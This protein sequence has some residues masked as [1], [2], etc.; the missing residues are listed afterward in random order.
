MNS[1]EEFK[2]FCT[3]GQH[4]LCKTLDIDMS[5][6]GDIMF[7]I[8]IMNK[9]Y[10]I[11]KWLVAFPNNNIRIKTPNNIAYV[12]SCIDGYLDVTKMLLDLDID[13]KYINMGFTECCATGNLEMCKELIIL[14]PYDNYNE[15]FE[16]S[17][18][19]NHMHMCQWILTLCPDATI[20][21]YIFNQC[22][23]NGH[24]EMCCWLLPNINN[25]V[26]IENKSPL[27]IGMFKYSPLMDIFVKCCQ[28]GHLKMC[29]WLYSQWI[30]IAMINNEISNPYYKSCSFISACESG[31]LE[32]CQWLHTI[33]NEY[34]KNINIVTISFDI[35]CRYGHLEICQWLHNEN[36]S[37]YIKPELLR[38]SLK[39]GHI[40]LFKW[41]QSLENVPKL[42]IDNDVFIESFTFGNLQTCQY[43]YS[44]P[45][46]I[47]SFNKAFYSAFEGGYV[48]ICQWL[49]TLDKHIEIECICNYNAFNRCCEENHVEMMKWILQ[50]TNILISNDDNMSFQTSLI[51]NHFEICKILLPM[52]LPKYQKINNIV[53]LD[54]CYNF[55]EKTIHA[56]IR[57]TEKSKCMDDCYNINNE[58]CK[59]LIL[60]ND[61]TEILEKFFE[62]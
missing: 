49:L 56:Y 16:I 54:K 57:N 58:M 34:V 6:Y 30:T 55:K 28:N 35:A 1:I 23:R 22:C 37:I 10:D 15:M 18:V 52:L 27:Y 4:E 48:N 11:C 25:I 47:T 14:T 21:N 53:N 44:L 29:K 51:N 2:Q 7:R 42:V 39:F 60:L 33:T 45:N 20:S 40:E 61:D 5:R 13:S 17:A 46:E 24:L 50:M 19:H 31:H 8:A 43:L 9:H 12:Q 36:P 32:I 59:W 26:M 38:K 3:T 62:N 41:L